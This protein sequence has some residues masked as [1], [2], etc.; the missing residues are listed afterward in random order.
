[1]KQFKFNFQLFAEPLDIPGI[2]EDIL[3]ELAEEDN[4]EEITEEVVE[5]AEEEHTEEPTAE[6]DSV[7]KEVEVADEFEDVK[8]GQT[9]PYDRFKSVN[10]RRKN[11]ESR[12]KELEEQLKQAKSVETA[13]KPEAEP[14]QSEKAEPEQ[15]VNT[16]DF[17]DEQEKRIY[18]IAAK[19]VKEKK[20]Y[21]DEDIEA[22]DYSDDPTAKMRYQKALSNEVNLVV[23]ELR[24]Y[25]EDQKRFSTMVAECN[26][27]FQKY[28]QQLSSYADAQERWRYISQERFNQ[29]PK[30][31]QDVINE[32]F[33]RLQ[34][35]KG[36]YTDIEIVSDYF[37]KANEEWE[38]ARSQGGKPK[39]K[40]NKLY[41]AQKLPKAPGIQ[42]G[43]GS[44]GVLTNERIADILNTPGAWEKLSQ[45]EQEAILSGRI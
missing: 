37:D 39:P 35:K 18:E 34:A 13:A 42:G 5:A 27:E 9:I 30:R 17:T 15:N 38:N 11:A 2:D 26:E 33:N 32:A 43:S 28:N 3:K 1:M 16:E 40:S 23:Q 6:A 31:R 29:L 20:N 10:E 36:T 7:N 8:E 19:R 25:A 44:D 4:S 45:K 24:Q 21:S 22:L 12:I 14:S 41:E